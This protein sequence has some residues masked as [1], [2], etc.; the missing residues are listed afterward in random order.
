MSRD[1]PYEPNLQCDEC[2][3]IG[4]YDMMDIL[5]PACL[6]KALGLGESDDQS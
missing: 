2:G 1:V 4:A 6:E 5:C 3:V